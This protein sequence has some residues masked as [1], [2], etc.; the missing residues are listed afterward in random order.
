[1]A[2]MLPP[3]PGPIGGSRRTRRLGAATARSQARARDNGVVTSRPASDTRSPDTAVAARLRDRYPRSRL[4]R[5]LLVGLIAAGSIIAL[6]WLL[7]AAYVHATP[8]VAAQVA[9]YA[10]PDDHKI[11]L[12]L[13]VQRRQ[14]E[15]AASCRVVAEAADFQTVGEQEVRV[16]PGPNRLTGVDV[17]LVTLR[18]A[19]TALVQSCSVGG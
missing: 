16:P 13:T 9:A 18:R 8:A 4:P 11:S 10:I 1:M 3:G 12:T 14:P 5:P 15:T 17:T 2:D 19:T 6:A 7:W